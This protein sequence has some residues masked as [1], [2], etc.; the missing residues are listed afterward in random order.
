MTDFVP[1]ELPLALDRVHGSRPSPGEIR[2]AL[3][4]AWQ[5][6]RGEADHEPLL[7]VQVEGRRH[8]FPA[9]RDDHAGELPEGRWRATFS[10]PDWAEP[11]REGQAAVWVGNA[12]VPVPPL[13]G[14][15]NGATR[16]AP[17]AP[18]P[19]ADRHAPPA[20][21]DAPAAPERAGH[22]LEPEAQVRAEGDA[23]QAQA[24]AEGPGLES[25]AEPPRSGPLADLLLRETVAALHGELE[26]RTAEVARLRGALEGARAELAA[27]TD[28]QA[29]LERTLS[30]L[31]EEL[32][33]LMRGAEAQ[34]SELEQHRTRA[35]E[36]EELERGLRE[37][38]AASQ[39]AREAALSELAGLQAE[40]GR[41]G[42]ELAVTRE[43][44]ASETGNLGQANRLLAEAKSL[45]EEIRR[46]RDG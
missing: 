37:E 43:R 23:A 46:E 33:R 21:N 12:V 31:T 32:G 9:D 8:R 20:L 42:A 35:T 17:P 26:Q 6:P 44:V 38:L 11:R 36:R 5:G 16:A 40:I 41:I 19:P 45:A 4:G 30:E 18:A 14:A 22:R 1:A 27:R 15:H 2:L 28:V 34:R 25:S 10:V 29:Q 39:V 24:P 7:V 13:H 3:S